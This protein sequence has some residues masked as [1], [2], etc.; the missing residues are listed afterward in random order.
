[1]SVINDMSR[2]IKETPFFRL[3]SHVEMAQ[4]G[5][6]LIE[7]L[8]V[9]AIIGI[10]SSIVLAS[11]N[12]A[13][14]KANNSKVK[15]QLHAVRSAAEIYYDN[16]ASSYAPV[17][18]GMAAGGATSCSAANSGGGMFVD[19]NSGMNGITGTASSW[20]SNLTIRCQSAA[21]AYA[22]SVL[23]PVPEVVGGVT[24]TYWCVDNT[25][26]SKGR[27]AAQGHITTTSC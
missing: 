10:L 4:K 11:L 2:R 23:L 19:V 7:L 17:V 16:N 1:M 15:E 12:T 25:G 22:V 13:R 14:G 5:F 26:A 18:S 6:T 3:S 21:Q 27:T 9:I 24:N 20:P 8:V